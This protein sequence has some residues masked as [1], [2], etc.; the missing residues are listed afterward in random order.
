MYKSIIVIGDQHGDFGSLN[1][2][3]CKKQPEIVLSTGD[4]GYWPKYKPVRVP[5][6]DFEMFNYIDALKPGNTKIYFAPG[7]HEHWDMLDKLEEEHGTVPIEVKKNVFYCPRG[8]HLT[9]PD[10]RGVL[11]VGGADSIDKEYRT[12]KI[13]WFPQ[14][15]TTQ[16][17]LDAI[18]RSLKV[19]ILIS[20]TCPDS[21]VPVMLDYNKA[22]YGDPTTLT[23]QR[24]YNF[25]TP[26]LWYFG[27][28]HHYKTGTMGDGKTLWTCLSHPRKT[29]WWCHLD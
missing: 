4:F 27:H 21:L 12:I 17:H 29:G 23:L 18:D 25:Y 28:W 1:A 19:D 10:G 3:I 24:L 2:L 22:K 15:I 7:N 9:L 6:K 20:H 8:S 16:R 13:D 5:R 14:E 11:F 26:S